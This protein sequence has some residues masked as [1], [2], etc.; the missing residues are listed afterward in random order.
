MVLCQP[1]SALLTM[2]TPTF[3]KSTFYVLHSAFSIH[4]LQIGVVGGGAA[5][6]G[7]RVPLAAD[8]HAHDV[9]CEVVVGALLVAVGEERRADAVDVDG[10]AE[11]LETLD[12]DGAEA[13]GDDDAHIAA[14]LLGALVPGRRQLPA[15]PGVVDGVAQVEHEARR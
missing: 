2:A 10:D 1:C 8:A 12:L 7:D 13:A 15:P 5:D 11:V 3:L 14:P 9:G 6:L 4:N